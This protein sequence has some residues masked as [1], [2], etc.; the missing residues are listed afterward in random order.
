MWL[1]GIS[2][3]RGADL[4]GS[5]C[6]MMGG[7]LL[8]RIPSGLLGSAGDRQGKVG[9]DDME[10]GEMHKRHAKSDLAHSTDPCRPSFKNSPGLRKK[11]G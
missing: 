9:D 6:W 5:I 2:T 1:G 8:G 10:D 4:D 7:C 3:E 11:A